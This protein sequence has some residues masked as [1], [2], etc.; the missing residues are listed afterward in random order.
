MPLKC[1]AVDIAAASSAE[2]PPSAA[3]VQTR[4]RERVVE[5]LASASGGWSGAILK[6]V[7]AEAGLRALRE[8]IGAAAVDTA[9]FESAMRERASQP[10]GS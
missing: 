10:Q 8:D 1:E 3:D 5:L 6:S 9:H 4:S 7:C 2:S